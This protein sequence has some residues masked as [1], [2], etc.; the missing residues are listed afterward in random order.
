[1]ADLEKRL[2]DSDDS[3]RLTHE[4]AREIERLN[5]KLDR[6]NRVTPEALARVLFE[7]LTRQYDESRAFGIRWLDGAAGMTDVDLEGHVDLVALALAAISAIK[8]PS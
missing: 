2:W 5:W 8:E 1:M 3:S 4:A 6:L 7:D